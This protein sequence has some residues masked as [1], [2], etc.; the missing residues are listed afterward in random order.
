MDRQ[1]ALAFL[2]DHSEHPRNYGPLAN[3]DMSF[4]GSYPCCEGVL[5]LYVCFESEGKVE[6][7][8]WEGVGGCTLCRAATSYVTMLVPGMT[9]EELE[10]MRDENLIEQLGREVAMTRPGCATAALRS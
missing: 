6:S 3:A 9:V 2:V 8:T 1:Q 7:V 10:Q 4:T 5:T